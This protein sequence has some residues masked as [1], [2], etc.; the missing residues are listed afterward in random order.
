MIDIEQLKS[1]ESTD[2]AAT[3]VLALFIISQGA[4]GVTVPQIVD[5]LGIDVLIYL[6]DVMR[7]PGFVSKKTTLV[8]GKPIWVHAFEGIPKH[9]QNRSEVLLDVEIRGT[10]SR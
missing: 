1:T 9:F 2:E 6:P 10:R 3:R 5:H 4:Q 7:H 8:N